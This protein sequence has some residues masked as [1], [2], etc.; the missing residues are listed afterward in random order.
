M[1]FDRRR[2]ALGVLLAIGITTAMDSS[3]LSAFS[4]LPL[5]PLMVLFWYME[6]LPRRSMGFVWGQGRH[7]LLAVLHPLGILGALA[8]ITAS[9]GVVD[10]SHAAWASALRNYAL[11]A[12]STIVVAILTEEGFFRGWLFASLEDKGLDRIRVLLWS[13]AAFALWHL[14]A[15]LLPTGFDL[16]R[17]RIP[18]FILNAGVLGATWGL[19]RRLSGSVIVASVSHGLWNGGAYIFFGYGTRTGALGIENTALYGPEV[20]ALGLALNLL[21]ALALW[22]W[23]KGKLPSHPEPAGGPPASPSPSPS[24]QHWARDSTPR[25]Q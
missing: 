23:S 24:N 21:F 14:S 3:G 2:T 1:P 13:S 22:R 17:S 20:G 5:F 19:M 4:A 6:R 10:T 15:V 12:I 9:A 8:I 7:Y 11:V 16:P 25:E 18:V